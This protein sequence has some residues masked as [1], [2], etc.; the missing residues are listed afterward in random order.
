MAGSTL[1]TPQTAAW[2]AT[3]Q[4]LERL[5][6]M[7]MLKTFGIL[8]VALCLV[9]TTLHA[10]QVTFKGTVVS[11]EKTSVKITVVDEKTKKP[12]QKSFDFDKETKILR[13]DKLVSIEQARIVKG[14]K[15]AVTIDHDVD[16]TLAIVIRLD[17]KAT[18][19]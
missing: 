9:G 6:L 5:P 12:V 10:H 19:E 13:G 17:P 7:N 16:E 18:G 1:Q 3:L 11:V 14:D 2:T 8:A 15:I 4:G